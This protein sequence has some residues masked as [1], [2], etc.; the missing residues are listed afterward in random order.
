VQKIWSGEEVSLLVSKYA[1]STNQ[2]LLK[3]FPGRTHLSLYK[4][5]TKLNLLRDDGIEFANRSEA[6]KKEPRKRLINRAGYALL[7][8]PS[9]SR[10]EKDGMALEHLAIW[11]KETGIK[12][13]AGMCIHHL[14]ENKSDNRISNLCMMSHAAHTVLHHTGT[15]QSESTKKLI[16]I[17]SKIRLADRTRHP[18][19]KNI[20]VLDLINERNAGGDIASIC[21]KYNICKYTFYKKIKEYRNVTE[22]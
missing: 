9:C 19:Y 20:N 16:S 7:Y 14:N 2:E 17:K 21:R 8:C 15:T 4:K 10:A 6:R 12:V 13:P 3:L 18:L 1:N 11:E 5:A 22:L